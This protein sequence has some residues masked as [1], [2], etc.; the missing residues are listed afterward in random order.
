MSLP[1][2]FWCLQLDTESESTL[3]TVDIY[4]REAQ[5]IIDYSSLTAELG[6]GQQLPSSLPR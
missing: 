1:R 6:V 4:E 3:A 5:L 2:F